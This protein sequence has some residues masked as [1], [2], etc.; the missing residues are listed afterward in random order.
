MQIGCAHRL[1]RTYGLM[2]G[3]EAVFSIGHDMGLEAAIDLFDMGLQVACVA[4]IREDGQDP[5]LL[6][7]LSKRR[8][9]YLCG[10]V[11]VKAH[12]QKHVNKVTIASL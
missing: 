1:A 5:D 8:I 11:A 7:E 4:D 2:P 3:R 6:A 9:P 10:W 12:G